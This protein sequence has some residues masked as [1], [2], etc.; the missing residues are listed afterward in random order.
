MANATGIHIDQRYLVGL[1]QND[2]GIIREIYSRFAEKVKLFICKNSGNVEDAADI[3]QES[4]M[5]IYEQARHKNLHLTCPFEPFFILVCKRKWL[6]S[7]KKRSHAPV[8]TDPENLSDIGEDVFA[9]AEI[10]EKNE[11]RSNLFLS[12]F[13]KLGEKCREII[14]ASLAGGAQEKIAE[15]LGVTYGY[16]RK[17]KSECMAQLMKMIEQKQKG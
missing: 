17:K 6:N 3:F 1:V 9:Q 4:L 7:L 11:Q 13:E 16:L 2:T 5:D 8:T 14:K 10:I 15:A 12:E